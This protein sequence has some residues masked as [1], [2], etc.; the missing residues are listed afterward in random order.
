MLPSEELIP[1][2]SASG[3]ELVLRETLLKV[4]LLTVC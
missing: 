2:A 3:I 1:L 4:T